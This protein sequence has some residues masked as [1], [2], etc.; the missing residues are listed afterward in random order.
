VSADREFASALVILLA[1]VVTNPAVS[2]AQSCEALDVDTSSPL[3]YQFRVDA[4]RCEGMYRYRVAGDQGMAL[5]SLTFGKVTYDTKQDQYLEIKLPAKPAEKT[6]IR[7]VGVPERLY[8]RLDFELGPE[9]SEF[10]LPLVDVIVP[11]N[12]LPDAFGIYGLRSLPGGENAFVPVYARGAGAAAQTEE[13]VAV[14]RPSADVMDVQWRR[15]DAPGLPTTAWV[16]VVGAS[17]LVPRGTRLEIPLGRDMPPQ[18]TLEVSFLLRG[19]GASTLFVL[20]TH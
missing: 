13:V 4:P 7:G 20:A 1:M 17:G 9:R 5:V 14:V 10:R 16:S 12:I 6:L 8:Y 19:V 15:R 3:S 18:M 11:G 2:V